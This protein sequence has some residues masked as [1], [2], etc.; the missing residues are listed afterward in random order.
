MKRHHKIGL[1]AS[2]LVIQILLIASVIYLG[3]NIVLLNQQLNST[4]ASLEKEILDNQQQTQSQII[5]LSEKIA[6]TETNLTRE[7]GELKAKTSEDFSGIISEAVTGVVS[8]RTNA[9]AGSG[10]IISPDGYVITNAH[11]LY[12]AYYAEVLTYDGAKQDAE[13]I[14]YDTDIDVAVLKIDGRHS[15]LKFERT[16]NVKVG[17]K[18]IAV[19]NPLGLS[20]SV[21]EGIVSAKDREGPNGMAIYIQTTAALNPGNSGGPLI[22]NEGKVIGI[23]NFKIQSTEGVGFALE[24][25]TAVQTI[26]KILNETLL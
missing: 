8:I 19:G 1:V 26:N 4:K 10:F 14:G 12:G 22:N 13:L 5:M 20:F 9:G 23:N 2:I 16:E 3:Q 7:I 21:T 25:D 6:S 17:E 24:S 11:V 18:V 15:Y